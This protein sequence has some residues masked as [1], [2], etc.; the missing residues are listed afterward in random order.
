M[1]KTN[2]T[3]F[4]CCGLRF[5][6]DEESPMCPNCGGLVTDIL[7]PNDLIVLTNTFYLLY[8]IKLPLKM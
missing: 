3:C 4:N 6:S 1:P 7:E 5:E 8:L 2:H